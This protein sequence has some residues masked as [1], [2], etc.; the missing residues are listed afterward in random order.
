MLPGLFRS[1]DLAA[2]F[3]LLVVLAILFYAT[4][5]FFQ[6]ASLPRLP[7]PQF[8]AVSE[9]RA[10]LIET[11]RALP[12]AESESSFKA[13]EAPVPA[14]GDDFVIPGGRFYTQTAAEPGQGYAVTD[15][16]GV[17]L[18]TAFQRLGGVEQLGYPISQRFTW[19]GVPT[20]VF[21]KL[22]LQW[23][24]S[25][26]G[27]FV[28][29]TLDLLHDRGRDQWLW[30]SYGVPPMADW[31]SDT[32]RDWAEVV[33]AH[34]AL[35]TDSVLREAY[36]AVEDPLLV[37]GLPMA[38]IERREDVLVLR[39]QRAIL[40]RWLV[41]KPWAAAG[42]VTVANAGELAREAGLFEEAG[43]G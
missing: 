24:A 9:E 3:V 30:D 10:Q 38:P 7:L 19:N 25:A 37:Y 32:G 40:Q 27:A 35:L 28:V 15:E 39:T 21:Q 23:P 14:E 17:Y 43:A 6:I 2:L 18:W 13:V 11:V 16:D 12:P 20:Q 26:Q 34:Q 41:E 33:E 42:Q 1:R 36:F 31:S 8:D 22:V 29:N 4:D 5:Y